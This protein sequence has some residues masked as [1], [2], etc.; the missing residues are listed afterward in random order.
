MRLIRVRYRSGQ[1]FLEHYENTF[2]Y[3]GVFYPTREALQVGTPV[4]IEIRFPGLTNRVLIRGSVEWRRAGRHSLGLR[5]G[6]GIAFAG[7]DVARRDFL[8]RVA[9]GEVPQAVVVHRR[10]RRFPV[11]TPAHWRDKAATSARAGTIADI[12]PGGAFVSDGTSL[13]SPGSDVV[14]TITPPGASLPLD[15]EGRVAWVRA[16]NG[17]A[18]E[19]KTRDVGGLRRIKEVVRRLTHV[20]LPA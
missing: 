4:A 10:F 12:G 13:P 16:A 15:V 14:L 3:G 18:L 19:F 6:L 2:V 11:N 17:F 20:S 7:A 1:N 9:R 8:L 5:A